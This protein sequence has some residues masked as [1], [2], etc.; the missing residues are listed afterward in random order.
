M[1]R[2][3]SPSCTGLATCCA[4]RF[5]H[6]GG[7]IIP[8]SMCHAAIAA[9]ASHF[10][11]EPFIFPT[12][13]SRVSW[14]PGAR[15]QI[16]VHNPKARQPPCVP[17]AHHARQRRIRRLHG[18]RTLRSPCCCALP[19]PRAPARQQC[20]QH[21][22]SAVRGCCLAGADC[23]RGRPAERR[24]R[25]PRCASFLGDCLRHWPWAGPRQGLVE[26]RGIGPGRNAAMHHTGHCAPQGEVS[27]WSHACSR[28]VQAAGARSH[29]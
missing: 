29:C 15:A 8:S 10:M 2:P 26:Q 25:S 7:L 16:L 6:T 4:G 27:T 24:A 20:Q 17:Q 5:G 3:Q 9:S 1:S 12:P 28:V 11:H 23:W 22:D 13:F 14:R 19:P 21:L 18:F